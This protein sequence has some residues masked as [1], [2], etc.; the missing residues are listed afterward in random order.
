M[1]AEPNRKMTI[2]LMCFVYNPPTTQALLE[3]MSGDFETGDN[4]DSEGS[5]GGDASDEDSK[6]GSKEPV[7]ENTVKVRLAKRPRPSPARGT[8]CNHAHPQP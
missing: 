4:V 7:V 3:L 8:C 5:D 1:E 6:S 2:E